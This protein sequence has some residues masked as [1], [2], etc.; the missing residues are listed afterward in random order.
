MI[1]KTSF[2]SDRTCINKHC[3][4]GNSVEEENE[5]IQ[6]ILRKASPATVWFYELNNWTSACKRQIFWLT[7]YCR[8]L[9]NLSGI[10]WESDTDNAH[11]LSPFLVAVACQRRKCCCVWECVT[12]TE[13]V[14]SVSRISAELWQK[15]RTRTDLRPEWCSWWWE[16]AWAAGLSS[17]SVFSFVNICW[18]L[19]QG[20]LA[21]PQCTSSEET[22]VH[23][24]LYT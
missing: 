11:S 3:N 19:H 15:R 24:V 10:S 5:N 22:L 6:N 14:T 23:L 21:R 7:S 20:V 4:A 8:I 17:L 16:L 18:A 13:C 12:R 1:S 2:N 9:S